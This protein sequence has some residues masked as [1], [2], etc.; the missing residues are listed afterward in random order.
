MT[1]PSPYSGG[2]REKVDQFRRLG[3]DEAS[4]NRPPSDAI[5]PDQHETLVILEAHEQFAND[6]K[7]F[8]A[9]LASHGAAA[10]QL[11]Q[12]CSE[13]ADEL[14]LVL[15]SDHLPAAVTEA[16]SAQ[17][18]PLVAATESR[19]RRE[20]DLKR[21]REINEIR[22]QASYPDSHWWH[23]AIIAVLA[24]IE[25]TTNAFF[26]VNNA[27]GL[28]GGFT[29][30]IGVS[31]VNMSGAL[32]LGSGFRYKNL[33][34]PVWKTTGV[35]SLV[36]FALLSVYCN[37]LFSAFRAEYQV[38]S[39]PADPMQLRR[40]FTLATGEATK[41]FTFDMHF[42]DL[43]SSVLFAFGFLL[44]CLAFYK[45]YTF[46]DR[47]PGHGPRD[48]AV[49]Q[50][51][52]KEMALE[53]TVRGEL[54]NLAFEARRDVQKAQ[55]KPGELVRRAGSRQTQLQV[56]KEALVRGERTINSDLELVLDAYRSANCAIRP[57]DAPAYFATFPK[58][59]AKDLEQEFVGLLTR[60]Q[61]VQTATRAIG[62]RFQ[63]Q[64]S[65]KLNAVVAQ[66]LQIDRG[67]DDFLEQV[68]IRAKNRIDGARS[69]LL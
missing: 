57:T 62:E 7:I 9:E 55:N 24:L 5:R 11:Q 8:H 21:L 36:A 50:A 1:M 49:R 41:V 18:E 56:A 19:L 29:V 4:S 3:Q 64:L 32:G 16:Q 26:F 6:K 45:G 59:D 58:I 34:A 46:D 20:T 13:L 38:L 14:E 2:L 33:A 22:D 44:S 51:A 39:D 43:M 30:A 48:R 28:L 17:R 54:K 10:V 37:A 68:D 69:A 31:V 40:A 12:E 27:T 66:G 52:E 67:F 53:N 15:A 65:T 42:A 25:T 47:Y 23:L 60:L 35:L 63:E 61:E